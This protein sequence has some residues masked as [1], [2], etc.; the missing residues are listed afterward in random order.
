MKRYKKLIYAKRVTE[1]AINPSPEMIVLLERAELRKAAA[2]L[3]M[4]AKQKVLDEHAA[5][6]ESEAKKMVDLLN[7]PKKVPKAKKVID[8][9][10]KGEPVDVAIKEITKEAK[11]DEQAG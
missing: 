5:F 8:E 3:E 11:K 4:A 7:A 6:A 9:I 2:E 10:P 1:G